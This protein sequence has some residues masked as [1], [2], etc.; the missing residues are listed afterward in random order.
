MTTPH[1]VETETWR[2]PPADELSPLYVPDDDGICYPSAFDLSAI[3]TMIQYLPQSYMQWALTN[4]FDDPMT[5][6]ASGMFIYYRQGIVSARVGPDVYVIP[7]ADRDRPRRSYFRWHEGLLP[8]FVLEVLSTSNHQRDTGFKRG[9]YESWGVPE[10]WLYDP[11]YDLERPLLDPPLQGLRLVEGRYADIP[12]AYDRESGLY[13]GHSAALGLDL[14]ANW[15]EF[16]FVN[17][18]TGEA[19]PDYVESERGRRAAEARAEAAEA[20]AQQLAEELRRL[21]GGG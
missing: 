4:W 2:P 8:S 3:D 18:A 17:P 20:H 7:G 12:V 15:E 14:R 1:I 21:R 19:L 6:V 10:Y 5:L 11:N 9:L 16:R 13:R